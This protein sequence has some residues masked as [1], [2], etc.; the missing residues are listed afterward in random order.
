MATPAKIATAAKIAKAPDLQTHV[1]LV[2]FG[3]VQI[4]EMVDFIPSL[5]E[6]G[7]G[8]YLPNDPAVLTELLG[9]LVAIVE[10]E[11]KV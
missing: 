7:R 11:V 8:Y 3:N 2:G 9:A 1:R 4:V 6:F 10:G 5:G